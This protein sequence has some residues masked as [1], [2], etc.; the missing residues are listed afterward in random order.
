M[1][2]ATRRNWSKESTCCLLAERDGVMTDTADLIE[3]ADPTRFSLCRLV[4]LRR[5]KVDGRPDGSAMTHQIPIELFIGRALRRCSA[6]FVPASRGRTSRTWDTR[7]LL[8]TGGLTPHQGSAPMVWGEIQIFASNL[9]QA[10]SC[11][12]ISDHSE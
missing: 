3:E 12:C 4:G 6:F 2:C 8:Y 1:A 5:H 11:Q 9:S 10:E 7:Y